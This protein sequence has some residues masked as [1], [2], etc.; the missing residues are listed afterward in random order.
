MKTRGIPL[1]LAALIQS[2]LAA[3]APADE[4]RDLS[5]FFPGYRSGLLVLDTTTG[6]AT[7]HSPELLGER[8][9]PCSTFKIPNSLIGLETG[10]IED[11]DFEIPWDG[12]MREREVWNRTHNLRT[13]IQNSVVWYYQELARRVGQER[14]QRYVSAFRY[15]NEDTSAGVDRFWLGASL[16]I[17]AV[18]EVDFLRRFEAGELPV[19]PRAM[20]IVKDILVQ[21]TAKGVVYRGKTGSC[22]DGPAAPDHGWWVGSLK[23]GDRLW[24]FA[25]IILG[26]GASGMLARPMTERALEELGVLPPPGPP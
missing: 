25:A 26:E 23:R 5:R 10:V 15:G 11:A 18:E 6:T 9:S 4:A 7:R 12:V 21:P 24:V 17:S 3:R 13:A 22:R 2:L 19:S 1:A 20:A 8:F 14:E 16:R